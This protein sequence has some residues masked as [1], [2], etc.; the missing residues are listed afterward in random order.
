MFIKKNHK[1]IGKSLECSLK[2]SQSHL[3]EEIFQ[4]WDSKRSRL[5]HAAF[6]KCPPTVCAKTAFALLREST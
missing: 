2:K 3:L 4:P 5:R 6:E 1:I